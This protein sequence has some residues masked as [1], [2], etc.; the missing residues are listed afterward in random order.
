MEEQ[1]EMSVGGYVKSVL[2]I[3]DTFISK[4]WVNVTLE[5]ISNV[6]CIIEMKILTFIGGIVSK[7]IILYYF[8]LSFIVLYFLFSIYF[9]SVLRCIVLVYMV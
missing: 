7:F 3:N 6:F 9:S 2:C 4:L 8:V 1:T 5:L